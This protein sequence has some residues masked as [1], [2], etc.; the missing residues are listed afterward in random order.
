MSKG[1]AT[2]PKVTYKRGCNWR[3]FQYQ[4]LI[5]SN[6]AV[7][8]TIQYSFDCLITHYCVSGIVKLIYSHCQP[9]FMFFRHHGV[10]II[11]FSVHLLV[12]KALPVPRISACWST[13]TPR[14]TLRDGELVLDRDEWVTYHDDFTILC[15]RW[16]QVIINVQCINSLW[17]IEH[18]QSDF[19][20]QT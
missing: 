4:M 15:V 19:H 12:I 2:M 3:L 20:Q 7:D 11:Q 5:S 10:L 8:R 16:L 6:E 17:W 13:P 1:D 9:I 14:K 18:T